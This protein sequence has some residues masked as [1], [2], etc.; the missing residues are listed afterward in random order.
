MIELFSI[1]RIPLSIQ[2]LI[3]IIIIIIIYKAIKLIP[4]M[5]IMLSLAD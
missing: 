1:L 3:I 2:L 4:V 5:N